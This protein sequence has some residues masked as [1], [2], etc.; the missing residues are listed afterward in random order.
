[1]S[2]EQLASM[3]RAAVEALMGF[4]G[5]VDR[6]WSGEGRGVCTGCSPC[7]LQ[8]KSVLLLVVQKVFEAQHAALSTS[9]KQH[10]LYRYC[11]CSL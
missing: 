9:D 4:Q 2:A 8:L 10:G 7:K 6:Q 11:Y 1:M 3:E 5:P